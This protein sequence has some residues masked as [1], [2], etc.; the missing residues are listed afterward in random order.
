MAIEYKL[1]FMR[2]SIIILLLWCVFL[3][4]HGQQNELTGKVLNNN[5]PLSGVQITLSNSN[6][7][8]TDISDESGSYALLNIPN[9]TYRLQFSRMGYRSHTE[10]ITFAQSSSLTRSASLPEDPLQLDQVV[11]TGTRSAI[12]QYEAP[13]IV[14][15]I[16]SSTL[17]N[18]QSLSVAEGLNFSPGL[19]VENNC[20]NCGFTQ[21]RINGLEGAY[22]QILIN[23]RP[24]FSALAGVYGLEM[25]PPNM[26]DRIEVVKGGGSALYGGNAIGGTVN[27][28]TRDP[29]KNRFEIGVNQAFTELEASDR[30]L[31]FSGSVVSDDLSKGM[32]AYGFNRERTF[33]DANGDG[34][35]E[36]TQL[37]NTTFGLDAFVKQA[38]K[39]KLKFHLNAINEF[40]RGGNQFSREPHQTDLTEQLQHTILGGGLTYE[41]MSDN[42]RHQVSAYSALQYTERDSYY[43]GGGRIL[44]PEDTLTAADR[45]ALNAYGESEDF[46]SMSGLQYQLGL[47]TQLNITVGTEFQFNDVTD[48]M[49]GYERRIDQQVAT[50]GTFL[51]AEWDPT[52]NL[53]FLFGGR[54]DRVRINGNYLLNEE[55]FENNRVLN[56]LV[57]RIS[58]RYA[59]SESLTARASYAQGYRA[60]QAYDE[61]LHIET[62]GGAAR[63]IRLSEELRNERS[64]SYT[65]SLNYANQLGQTQL[66]LVLEGFYTALLNPFILAN[67]REL[68][69]GVAVIDKRNGDGATVQ[70]FNLESN[71]AFTNEFVVQSGVTVQT[72][73]Y[74][75]TE[76]L[77]E[78]EEANSTQPATTTD[79]LLRT[80]NVYGFAT[81]N[82]TGINRLDISLS[83][84][85]TGTMDVAHV[86]DPETEFTVIE[87]TPSFWELN[88]RA[89]YTLP[90]QNNLAMEFFGGIQNMF[91]AFQSDLDIGAE[92]DAGYIYG[93]MRPRTIFG[94]LKL[95]FN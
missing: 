13:T 89:A 88:T 31:Q 16:G 75:T 45:L 72:A 83:S 11:V 85:Y 67:Q 62:V 77:W 61:D 82:Y 21:L 64:N 1:T 5:L 87:Q 26:I 74:N 32:T 17:N 42:G 36:L 49:P 79:R 12:P 40:R 59:L 3:A 69:N 8:A 95:R 68:P 10:Q 33:W 70:G 22:S 56:V 24:V 58:A 39:Q 73:T 94:G 52:E 71:V 14:N 15:R 41:W 66:N 19:R 2:I 81:L 28:I 93:P 60:P 20:Q 30:T 6:Y 37:R 57:P 54:Y 35:S 48:A 55:N 25:I 29:V 4:S 80:P 18:T 46:A 90:L 53:T 76:V 65:A 27:I 43:G 38:G 50:L 51:Q 34:F 7:L 23:S 91:N 92:R 84:V 63:F 9:G 44:Q 47:L 78:S 86:I